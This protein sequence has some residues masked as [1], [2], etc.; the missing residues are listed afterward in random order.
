MNELKKKVADFDW[1][2]NTLFI[3]L[4]TEMVDYTNKLYPF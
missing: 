3:E 1:F 4:I 2:D